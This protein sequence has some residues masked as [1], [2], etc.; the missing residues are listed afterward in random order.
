MVLLL[1]A[2]TGRAQDPALPATNLGLANIQDAC[3]PGPGLYYIHYLQVY[4]P[5]GVNDAAGRPLQRTKVSSLLSM[6]QFIYEL[7]VQVARGD[8]G[9]SLLIPVVKLSAGKGPD[10]LRVNPGVLGGFIFG[11][12]IQWS[13]KRLGTLPFAHRA[14]LDVAVPAGAYSTDYDVNPSAH[15]FTFTA[16]HAFTLSPVKGLSLSAR[17]MLN[18]N[19][20]KPGTGIR[21]GLFY[22]IN[23]S[24]E[25]T[26][27]KSLRLALTGYYLKQLVQDS[28]NGDTHF[29]QDNFGISDT[30][31]QV[32]GLGPGLSFALKSGLAA[33]LKVFFETAGR[34]RTEGIRPTFKIAYKLK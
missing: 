25:Q 10:Q 33:E 12:F 16:Y 1:F 9:F 31:E 3:S 5:S 30:R 24:A 28:R 17:N 14:E 11:P 6:H 8:L 29:F 7:P 2:A 27:Y 26:V 20:P 21:S 34:N 22:N 4:N 23:F 15:F 19:L 18:Y 32:L 13:D